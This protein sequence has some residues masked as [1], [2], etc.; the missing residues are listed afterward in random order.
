M[1]ASLPE[2]LL[3][4]V[5]TALKSA[6]RD[7]LVAEVGEAVGSQEFV[8]SGEAAE[9]LGVSSTNTVKN[10]LESGLFPGARKTEGGHWRFDRAE[11]EL[12]KA[13]MAVLEKK[14]RARDFTSDDVPDSE[15]EPP[16]Y[17]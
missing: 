1:N 12:V 16:P 11:V 17:L 7:D 2:P 10:W 15:Q 9:P 8:T 3:Q 4:K 6:G 14:N 5:M 13:R